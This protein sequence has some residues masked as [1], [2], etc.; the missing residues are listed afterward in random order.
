MPE[1]GHLSFGVLV[2]EV[3]A[4]QATPQENWAALQEAWKPFSV[5]WKA[6]WWESAATPED[7]TPEAFSAGGF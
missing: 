3:A 7:M 1:K 4:R 5:A 6:P 2:G